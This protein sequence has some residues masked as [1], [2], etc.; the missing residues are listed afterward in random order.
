M[1]FNLFSIFKRNKPNEPAITPAT[2]S[3]DQAVAP[4]NFGPMANINSQPSVVPDNAAVAPKTDFTTTAQT[5][6]PAQPVNNYFEPMAKMASQ[7]IT[8]PLY[9]NSAPVEPVA[10]TYQPASPSSDVIADVLPQSTVPPENNS[11]SS[12]TPTNQI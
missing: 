10:T 7:P 2:P 9:T 12:P 11:P 4:T 8:N 3:Q 1:K 5:T 6:T